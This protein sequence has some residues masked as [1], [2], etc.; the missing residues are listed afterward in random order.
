ME[1]SAASARINAILAGLPEDKRT[2]LQG[3]RERILGMVPGA[4]ETI[5]YQMPGVRYRGQVLVTYAGF[6]DHC[7]FFPMGSSI[8]DEHPDLVAGFRTAKGTLQFTPANPL[9]PELIELIVRERMAQVEART[10]RR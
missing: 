10:R 4:E 3:I 1:P 7:S 8:M 5:S 6:K 9:P 2:T